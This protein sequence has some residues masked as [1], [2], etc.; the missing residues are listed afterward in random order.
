MPANLVEHPPSE[1]IAP[2]LMEPG[3]LAEL[4]QPASVES[5][6][7]DGVK[8]PY[9]R[10]PSWTRAEIDAF[11]AGFAEDPKA[12]LHE[13]RGLDQ[14]TRGLRWVISDAV[15]IWVDDAPCTLGAAREW[16]REILREGRYFRKAKELAGLVVSE[17]DRRFG[18]IEEP[19]LFDD[20]SRNSSDAH[21][22]IR[23]RIT[24]P[25]SHNPDQ[26]LLFDIF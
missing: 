10:V 23:S 17:L 13:L 1:T 11:K 26:K 12:A 8:S 14:R 15:G 2:D 5:S 20:Q 9:Y 4:R 24:N 16:T 21:P 22:V 3:S 19:R 18:K 25:P 7:I 6:D